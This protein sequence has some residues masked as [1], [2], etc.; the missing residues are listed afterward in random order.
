[1]Y[2]CLDKIS[3]GSQGD[4]YRVQRHD[5][6]AEFALKRVQLKEGRPSIRQSIVNEASLLSFF[7]SK[8]LVKCWELYEF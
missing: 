7:N 5:D 1:M 8:F 2:K 3:S 4:V 6:G